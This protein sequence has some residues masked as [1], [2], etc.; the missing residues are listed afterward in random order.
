MKK[1]I[2]WKSYQIGSAAANTAAGSSEALGHQVK[3]GRLP[4]DG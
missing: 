2:F 3:I 1:V 4:G